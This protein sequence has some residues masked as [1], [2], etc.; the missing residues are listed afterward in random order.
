MDCDV[1]Q[2]RG[3]PSDQSGCNV[4]DMTEVFGLVLE[5]TASAAAAGHHH[6]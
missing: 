6:T 5:D 2:V 3:P 4:F 1:G